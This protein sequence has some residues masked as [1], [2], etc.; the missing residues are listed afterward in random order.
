MKY[1]DGQEIKEGDIVTADGSEGVVIRIATKES[2]SV[3]QSGCSFLKS[4]LFVET[5]EMGLV[6]YPV[7]DKDLKLIGR[8]K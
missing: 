2:A 3:D 4:G 5:K 6:H 1:Q 7:P 8:A